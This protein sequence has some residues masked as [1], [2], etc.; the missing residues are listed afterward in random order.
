MYRSTSS[1]VCVYYA[2]AVFIIRALGY[3]IYGLVSLDGNI[4]D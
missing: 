2:T 4:R 1:S 3:L